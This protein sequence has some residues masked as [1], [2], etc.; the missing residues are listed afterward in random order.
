M[1]EQQSANTAQSQSLV[2]NRESLEAIL[3]AVRVVQRG[4]LDADP[5][6]RKLDWIFV[7]F[8]EQI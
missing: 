6:P 4:Q 2:R 7:E 3:D 1:I 8:L 5:I